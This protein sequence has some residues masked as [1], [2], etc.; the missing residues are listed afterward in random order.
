MLFPTSFPGTGELNDPCD[1]AVVEGDVLTVR[2]WCLFDG[3]RV[4]RVKVVVDGRWV[5]LARPYVERPDVGERYCHPDAPVGGFEALIS[6]D[7][8]DRSTESLVTVEAT[9]LDGR[10]WR[11]QTHRASWAPPGA[12]V[13]PRGELLVRRSI[14]AVERL[15]AGGTR[16]V[17]FTHDLSRGE[18]Q[19]WLFELLRQLAVESALECMVVSVA[20]GPLRSMLEDLGIR[21]HVTAPWPMD[22]VDRYEGRIHELAV[23]I[24]ASAAGAVL[25]NGLGVFPAVDA[26][27]RAGVPSLWAIHESFDPAVYRYICWGPSG[28]HPHV[29]SR[30]DECFRSTR[31]LILEARQTADMFAVHST[32]DKRFILDYGVDVDAIDAYRTSVDRSALRSKAGFDDD[33]VVVV[34]V[35]MLEPRK[36][37]AAVVAAFDELAVVHDRLRLALVGCQPGLYTDCV[38]EQLARCAAGDRVQLVP[39]TP[40]IY[41]WYMVADILVCASDVESSPRSI[42]E[43]M[44]FELPVVSTDASGIA[45]LIADARTGWPTRARDLEGLVGLLHLVLRLPADQRRAV[46]ARARTEVLGRHRDHRYGLTIGRALADLLDDPSCDLAPAFSHAHAE[47]LAS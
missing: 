30:F 24:R 33:S 45:D 23:L 11:S 22:D 16:V 36:A 2:G 40:D 13:A 47:E 41:P 31:A 9:S 37:Q 27:A 32:P 35:G 29:R 12:E 17:V 20:D 43:A 28:M 46:G 18:G 38:R 26:A 14:A 6:F 4:A 21:V 5:G 34:V 10:R 42:L 7:R 15:P 25:V 44:T 39:I 3:S 8:R 19:L 1:G